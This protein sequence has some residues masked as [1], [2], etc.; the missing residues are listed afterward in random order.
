MEF[1]SNT[2]P[3]RGLYTIGVIRK[4]GKGLS[5]SSALAPVRVRLLVFLFCSIPCGPW[6]GFGNSLMSSSGWTAP[7]ASGMAAT[8]WPVSPSSTVPKLPWRSCWTPSP[9]DAP[10]GTRSA[11]R[12]E[13]TRRNAVRDSPT[14]GQEPHALPTCR[15]PSARSVSFQVGGPAPNRTQPGKIE[16]PAADRVNR[17]PPPV[18]SCE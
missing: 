17:R 13:S 3:E 10:G 16:K 14:S 4:L 2:G 1:P 6:S 5:T 12:R 7:C 8:A 15:P 18:T 9:T 11:A